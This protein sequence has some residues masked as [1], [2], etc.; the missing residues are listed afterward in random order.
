[1]LGRLL[2]GTVRSLLL[3]VRIYRQILT[4]RSIADDHDVA[5]TLLLRALIAAVGVCRH[6]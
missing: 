3:L 1:M 5:L 6:F 2:A 4:L